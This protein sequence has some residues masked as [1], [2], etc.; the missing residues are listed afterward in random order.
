MI[1]MRT[2]SVVGYV[3]QSSE[4]HHCGYCG[5]NGSRHAAE[6]KRKHEEGNDTQQI[7]TKSHNDNVKKSIDGE[8]GKNQR[9]ASVLHQN[10]VEAK[11]T[12]RGPDPTK[13][14]RRKAK[15]IRREKKLEKL[16]RESDMTTEQIKK[17][18]EEAKE[19]EVKENIQKRVQILDELFKQ[20]APTLTPGH[21][22]EV[23]LVLADRSLPQFQLTFKKSHEIYQ[24]YQMAIHNDRPDECDEGQF[25]RFLVD[26]ALMFERSPEFPSTGCGTFHQQYY[27][28]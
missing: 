10:N 18:I 2:S 3:P 15:D 21:K 4:P 27:L 20:M 8:K 13:P 11:A 23:K 6:L 12:S 17:H 7:D 16:S 1:S 14:K 22:L 28:D 19:K 5:K 25:K 9:D 26:T 24:K